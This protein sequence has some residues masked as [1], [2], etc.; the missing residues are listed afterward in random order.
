[1]RLVWFGVLGAALASAGCLEVGEAPF[2]TVATDAGALEIDAAPDAAP[3]P[4]TLTHS[5][6]PGSVTAANTVACVQQQ[7][8]GNGN[9][10]PVYH[11]DNSYYRVFDLP[12]LGVDRDLAIEAVVFGVESAR[13][14]ADAADQTVEVRLHT[15]AGPLQVANLT[16]LARAPVTVADG[17]SQEILEVDIAAVAPAGSTLVVELFVPSGDPDRLLFI[18]SNTAGQSAPTF[19]RAPACDDDANAETPSAFEEPLDLTPF[20]PDMHVVVSVSG[21]Y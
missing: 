7:D 14:G 3:V 20:F 15:L 10:V 19:L 2:T 16:Q 5:T 18:G 1:M 17:V 8:D 9:T 21:T 12:A 4:V 6:D 13:G 11:Q